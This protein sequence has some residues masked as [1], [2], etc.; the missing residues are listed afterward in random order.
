MIALLA[1]LFPGSLQP[2]GEVLH[3]TAE[4]PSDALP[5]TELVHSPEA[6]ARTLRL[7][8]QHLGVTSHDMRPAASAWSLQYAGALLPPMVAAASVLQHVFPAAVGEMWVRF[9]GHGIPR[10]FHIRTLGRPMPGSATAQRYSALLWQHLEPLTAALCRLSGVAPKILWSNT[11]RTL[12]PILAQA[13]AL[14]GGSPTLALDAHQL[15]HTPTWP[16][17]AQGPARTN[18]LLGAQREVSRRTPNGAS[19]TVRLHR[20]CCLNYLLP[21]EN[22]CGFCPLAPEHRKAV[23]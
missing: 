11:A 14:T 13:I 8:A 15:L 7:H 19:Q 18:A 12:E 20:Q 10:A 6:L 23:Q 22:Y 5:V 9:D 3:C 17:D 1:P 21:G 16:A 2:L 4:P